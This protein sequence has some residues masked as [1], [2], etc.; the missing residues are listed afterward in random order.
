MSQSEFKEFD[1]LWGGYIYSIN[2]DFFTHRVLIC[3]KVTNNKISRYF[4][5]EFKNVSEIH[6][7]TE[8]KLNPRNS[9]ELTSISVE[10]NK[11]YVASIDIWM[12]DNLIKI[13]CEDIKMEMITEDNECS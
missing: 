5:L 3:V 1:I 9:L 4:S 8:S 13:V 6:Y 10:K 11:K 12:E 2:Y 7:K